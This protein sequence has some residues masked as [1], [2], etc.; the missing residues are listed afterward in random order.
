VLTLATDPITVTI[1]GLVIAA[2]T[3][4]TLEAR[5]RWQQTATA[6]RTHR[7]NE[8]RRIQRAAQL[9][10][11]RPHLLTAD[12]ITSRAT[13]HRANGHNRTPTGEGRSKAAGQ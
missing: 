3:L 2:A 7:A 1:A 5:R 11:V 6:R 13:A 12:E 10:D 9:P 4:T 8:L